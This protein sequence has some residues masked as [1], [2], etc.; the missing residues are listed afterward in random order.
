MEIGSLR[1]Y[2]AANRF[3][4][5][6]IARYTILL[7]TAFNKFYHEC[8]I[9]NADENL[10]DARLIAVEL[11]QKTIKDAMGLLGIDCPEEM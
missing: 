6:V 10:R 9:L 3:E 4:P 11:T 2:E 7:S 1:N 8:N 5:S